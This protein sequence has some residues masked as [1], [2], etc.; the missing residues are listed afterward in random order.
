MDLK[1]TGELFIQKM[2]KVNIYPI[3]QEHKMQQQNSKLFKTVNESFNKQSHETI[4]Q[5][6]RIGSILLLQ[7]LISI[8]SN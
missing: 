6:L 7:K 5:Q 8:L 2:A 4:K 3:N 1:K